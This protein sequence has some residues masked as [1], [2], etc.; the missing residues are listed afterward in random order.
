[1]LSLNAGS[2]QTLDLGQVG[3]AL[4]A[5]K[6]KLA[7]EQQRARDMKQI[8]GPRPEAIGVGGRKPTRPIHRHVH[9][10]RD[11]VDEAQQEAAVGINPHRRDSSSRVTALTGDRGLRSA[12]SS[13][14]SMA[15]ARSASFSSL[16]TG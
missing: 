6:E 3:L 8:N 7:L 15:R 1:M 11:F 13:S 10:Q 4:V 16:V 9:V 5:G 2:P 14:S 12:S